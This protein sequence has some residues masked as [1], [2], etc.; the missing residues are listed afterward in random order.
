MKKFKELVY[1]CMDI[2]LIPTE[3]H[4]ASVPVVD[5]NREAMHGKLHGWKFTR[6]KRVWNAQIIEKEGLSNKTAEWLDKF[7]SDELVFGNASSGVN[8]YV[9]TKVNFC[10]ILN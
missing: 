2:E 4:Y 3:L 5:G 9:P 1:S 8:I 7:W 10:I 6:Q